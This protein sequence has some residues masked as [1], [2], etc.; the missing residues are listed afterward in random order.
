[1][2]GGF[3]GGIMKKKIISIFLILCITILSSVPAF[4]SSGGGVGIIE[5]ESIWS[6]IETLAL[7]LGVTVDFND[8]L[9][10]SKNVD[11]FK[12]QFIDQQQERLDNGEITQTEFN[13]LVA[14]YDTMIGNFRDHSIVDVP[15]ELWYAFTKWAW[16][17]IEVTTDLYPLLLNSQKAFFDNWEGMCAIYSVVYP[18]QL[19]VPSNTHTVAVFGNGC[20]SQPIY[21]NAWNKPAPNQDEKFSYWK[22]YESQTQNA[23]YY[24]DSES[25]ERY[26]IKIGYCYFDD[27]TVNVQFWDYKEKNEVP[28][29]SENENALI[30]DSSYQD[31]LD[32]L[33]DIYSLLDGKIVVTDTGEQPK[34]LDGE[35]L[36]DTI[37]AVQD[38]TVPWDQAIPNVFSNTDTGAIEGETPVIGKKALDEMVTGLRIQR[39]RQKFPFCIPD[40]IKTMFSGAAELSDEAPTIII[41]CH[42]EFA[43]H[44][45]FDDDE[46]I[47]IDFN[48][49]ESVIVIFRSGF[50]LLFL[51]GLIWATI[52][53]L[54]AFFVVTE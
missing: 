35:D 52:E 40:D 29:V 47:T 43:G 13:N 50:F 3:F 18:D 2:L 30:G 28:A 41:P 19:G 31:Y 6:G 12:E 51:V 25:S 20:L 48:D 23:I 53:V 4:A 21:Q 45:Y 24:Y 46:L 11:L 39:I 32:R 15:S 14:S 22:I 37:A 17:Q 7:M 49:F 38:G 26:S 16:S 27:V 10:T 1:M 36:A 33:N 54:Q 9:T 42:I 34:V 44:V 8:K 5:A